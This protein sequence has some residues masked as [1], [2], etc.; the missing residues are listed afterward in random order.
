VLSRNPTY[1]DAPR[2]YLDEVIFKVVPD[3]AQRTDAFIAGQGDAVFLTIS[4]ANPKRIREAG[5]DQKFVGLF[6]G[7]AMQFNTALAPTDDPRVRQALVA[8]FIPDD[9]NA[10]ATDGNSKTVDTFFPSDSPFYNQSVVQA[11]NDLPRAKQLIEEYVAE[12]G[13]PVSIHLVGYPQLQSWFET[14]A[15]QWEAIGNVDVTVDIQELTAAQKA[16]FDGAFNATIISI[17]GQDPEPS[18]TNALTTGSSENFMKYSNPTVDQALLAG[19]A[20]ADVALRKTA[21]DT[22]TTELFKDA[23]LVILYRA[24]YYTSVAKNVEGLSV[25]DQ[26]EMDIS[27][28]SFK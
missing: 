1:W 10:K 22:V 21:Y 2:P 6:G 16:R 25:Y 11:T 13:G 26:G 7:T 27:Q 14:V 20:T 9:A 18:L 8:A 24:E 15:Q 12:K 17:T 23:P 5:F 4:D 28:L 19:K 3:N